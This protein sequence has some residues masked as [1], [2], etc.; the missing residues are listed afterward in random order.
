[1]SIVCVLKPYWARP[2]CGRGFAALLNMPV[3]RFLVHNTKTGNKSTI[4]GRFG[5]FEA[6]DQSYPS[7]STLHS[8]LKEPVLA[9]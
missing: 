6:N 3:M 1:M 4:L 8:S 7:F 2:L 5:S 9:S